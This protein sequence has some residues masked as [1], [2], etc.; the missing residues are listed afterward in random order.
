MSDVHSQICCLQ[1][2]QENVVDYQ[3]ETTRVLLLHKV[4]CTLYSKYY[5]T[6]IGFL[7]ESG[8]YSIMTISNFVK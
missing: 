7:N 1:D 2:E 8:I 3:Y 6:T 5:T 4:G